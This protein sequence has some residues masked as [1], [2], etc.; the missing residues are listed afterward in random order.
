MI[1]GALMPHEQHALRRAAGAP[2]QYANTHQAALAIA[3]DALGDDRW[4]ELSVRDQWLA[5]NVVRIA[6]ETCT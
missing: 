6:W 3:Q 4:M 2:G 1:H 5:L